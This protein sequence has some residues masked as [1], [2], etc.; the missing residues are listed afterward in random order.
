MKPWSTR[1]RRQP[2]QLLVIFL[3]I[4]RFV[5]ALRA[6]EGPIDYLRDVKPLLAKHCTACHGSR[7]QESGLRL[8]TVADLRAGGDSGPSIVAGKA[9]ESRL[10]QAIEATNGVSRMPPEDRPSLKADEIKILRRWI[11]DGAA[12][13]VT[14]E[15]PTVETKHW[16]FQ[17]PAAAVPPLVRQRAWARS[18]IDLLILQ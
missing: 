6:D 8:D 5:T 9:A 17:P 7:T 3:L 14:E 10:I 4:G 13:P 16:A 1:M 18:P 11:D 12:A 2:S 15:R